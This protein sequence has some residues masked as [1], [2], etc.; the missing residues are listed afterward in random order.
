MSASRNLLFQK[1]GVVLCLFPKVCLTSITSIL[2]AYKKRRRL[3][4][5]ELAETKAHR[6]GLVR[7]PLSRLVSC[8]RDKVCS[9]PHK[10]LLRSIGLKGGASFRDF[11]IAVHATDDGAIER[12]L[13]SQS[14]WVVHDGQIHLD[15]IYKFEH[16]PD[17]WLG[18]R[19]ECAARGLHLPKHLGHLNRLDDGTP[20]ESFYDADLARLAA[21]RYADDLAIFGYGIPNQ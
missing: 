7:H 3:R 8:W 5:A 11:V 12:H 9:K 19:S 4:P 15:A 21:E 18:I 2:P 16:M 20:W 14:H 17:A 13:K 10:W 6:I 1:E